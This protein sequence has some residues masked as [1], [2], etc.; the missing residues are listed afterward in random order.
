M[1]NYTY[2]VYQVKADEDFCFMRWGW[3]R[4]H[5]WSFKPYKDVWNGSEEARDDYDLLNY[6][7]ELLNES[8]P[9]GFRGHSMSVSDVVMICDDD[10]SRYY[11]CD[12]FGWEDI[13]DNVMKE[14]RGQLC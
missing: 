13:T 11:Y 3:A 4:E 10:G 5:G 12:S 7:Y 6:L 1:K 2:I 9:A 14:M 8:H